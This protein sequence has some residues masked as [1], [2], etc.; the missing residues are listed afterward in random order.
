MYYKDI[1]LENKS[2]LKKQ[3][4]LLREALRKTHDKSSVINEIRYEGLTFY[5][6]KDIATQFNKHFTTIANKI[7]ENINPSFSDP[8]ELLNESNSLFTLGQIIDIS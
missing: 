6:H 2:D 3:W 1:I 7:E 4:Q 8:C 5:S